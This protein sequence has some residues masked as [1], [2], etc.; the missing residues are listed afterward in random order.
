MYPISRLRRLRM[1]PNLRALVRETALEPADFIAPLFVVHGSGIREEI[2]TMPGQYRLS[3]DELVKECEGLYSVG[4]LSVML[5]GIPEHKDH[6]GSEAYSHNG[7]VQQGIRALKAALPDLIV[8]AD[9][10][11]CEYTDHGHCGILHDHYT[12]DNDATLPYLCRQAVSFA[13]AGA[14]IVAPS[15]MMDGRIAAMRQALDEAGYEQL[16]IMSYAAKFSS[17]FYG[18]FRDAADSAPSF[19]DRRSYQIRILRTSVK[20][21]V[22]SKATSPKVL[23]S[24]WSSPHCPTSTSSAGH[25]TATT[26]PW[27]PIRSVANMP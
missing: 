26:C 6:T 7:I 4:V 17:A 27:P 16:P 18:P 13:E 19:G 8:I 22:R 20:L 14:D 9:I 2:K 3:V 1:T 25:A 10:C 5:F 23:T 11:M 21:C 15:D 12:V 24:L